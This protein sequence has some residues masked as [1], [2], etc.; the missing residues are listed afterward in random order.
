MKSFS[1]KEIL[2]MEK[3]MIE[4]KKIKEKK[5]LSHLENLKN[6]EKEISFYTKENNFIPSSFS[7]K[8]KDKTL[9]LNNNKILSNNKFNYY[10]L[11]YIEKIFNKSFNKNFISFHQAKFI[12]TFINKSKNNKLLF[13]NLKNNNFITKNAVNN[14]LKNKYKIYTIKNLKLELNKLKGSARKRLNYYL[15]SRNFNQNI[16]LNQAFNTLKI[17]RLFL[18][19]PVIINNLNNKIINN[20]FKI[21]YIIFYFQ[22][23]Q[24]I[25]SSFIDKNLL[26]F[27]NTVRQGLSF[28]KLNSTSNNQILNKLFII[29]DSFKNKNTHLKEIENKI[30]LLIKVIILFIY[31]KNRKLI[32]KNFKF[33]L[34]PG[35][36]ALTDKVKEG[37]VNKN[38]NLLQNK[39]KYFKFDN[40]FHFI[41]NN[42]SLKKFKKSNLTSDHHPIIQYKNLF[43]KLLIKT[44]N[45]YELNNKNKLFSYFNNINKNNNLF[46][47]S[48]PEYGIEPKLR[49]LLYL[50]NN[51]NNMGN[52]QAILY[53]FLS[54]SRRINTIESFDYI[55]SQVK[56]N[57]SVLLKYFFFKVGPAL[58]SKPVFIFNHNKLIIKLGY[59]INKKIYFYP[60]SYGK[61]LI[62]KLKSKD[63][64]KWIANLKGPLK[65][66][67]IRQFTYLLN[68]WKNFLKY[69][70]NK[71]I[72]VSPNQNNK[73]LPNTSISDWKGRAGLNSRLDL[74]NN[75]NLTFLSKKKE[76]KNKF[77]ILNVKN[78]ILFSLKDKLNA[79]ILF[80]ENYF[81]LPIQ[82]ELTRILNPLLDSNMM[83]Q[84]INFNGKS[85]KNKNFFKIIKSIFKKTR[86]LNPR[87]Q[88]S[89]INF[90]PKNNFSLPSHISG[91]KIKLAGRFYRSRIIPKRTVF[92]VQKGCISRS[93]VNFI[94][95][96][97]FIG[98]SK[99]GSFCISISISHIFK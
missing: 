85:T 84:I 76:N 91:I 92:T 53:N 32:N 30:E 70:N 18:M 89:K 78:S 54:T 27:P 55:G 45:N 19:S 75:K 99:R 24:N 3:I 23:G 38:I 88:L 41:K 26:F 98:K 16:N 56:K 33:Y 82:L 31:Y 74:I 79:L 50:Q 46:T 9:L 25:N 73:L 57:I 17:L 10:S 77:I 52:N 43:N 44:L 22:P 21:L 72:Y 1:I 7:L 15:L 94:E 36:L 47:S 97:R 59:Y 40:K 65:I 5:I 64:K 69:K 83:T 11:S 4:D 60:Y 14:K 68:D 34:Q 20:L 95:K 8:T 35:I 42:W 48:Q 81:K 62:K 86:I 67:Y 71:F 12:N 93:S 66:K 96:S 63:S 49:K 61:Y 13:S 6:Y 28:N 58:I 90:L 80:L 29:S 2:K 39:Y 37:Q 51:V 87:K